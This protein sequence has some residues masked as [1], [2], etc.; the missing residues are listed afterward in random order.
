MLYDFSSLMENCS[1]KRG[2]SYCMQY[3]NDSKKCLLKIFSLY[4]DGVCLLAHLGT[5]QYRGALCN[6]P[7]WPCICL[8]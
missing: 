8:E 6:N 1:T 3:V 7:G 5:D 4:D 2:Y